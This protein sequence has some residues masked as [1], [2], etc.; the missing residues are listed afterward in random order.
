MDLSARNYQ[1]ACSNHVHKNK[2][3]SAGSLVVWIDVSMVTPHIV[4]EC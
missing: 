3:F 2:A 4:K 1:I